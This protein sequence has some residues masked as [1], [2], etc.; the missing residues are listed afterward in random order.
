[1]VCESCH[2]KISHSNYDAHVE[3]HMRRQ[4]FATICTILEDAAE[5]KE[6]V[7]VAGRSGI[8]FGV[9]ETPHSV[10]VAISITSTE[11]TVSLQKCQMRSSSTP[12]EHRVK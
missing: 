1:M 10:E 8:D 6:G 7:K 2:K 3:E 4:R 12:G 5:D 9:L 11:S